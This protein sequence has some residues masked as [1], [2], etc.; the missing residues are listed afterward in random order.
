MTTARQLQPTPMEE[1][2]AACGCGGRECDARAALVAG[3]LTDT[4]GLN[5]TQRKLLRTLKAAQRRA[6]GA[7]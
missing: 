6:N 3:W 1:H 4:V 5:R 2:L 7:R